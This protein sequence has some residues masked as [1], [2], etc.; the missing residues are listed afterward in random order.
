MPGKRDLTVS[1]LIYYLHNNVKHSLA[2]TVNATL[3]S[4]SICCISQLISDLLIFVLVLESL[5]H[6]TSFEVMCRG[7]FLLSLA[8]VFC[9]STSSHH[10][11]WQVLERTQWCRE[12]LLESVVKILVKFITWW[13]D[14]VSLLIV[15][16]QFWSEPMAMSFGVDYQGCR[17]SKAHEEQRP[18]GIVAGQ[19]LS[20]NSNGC[21]LSLPAEA[22]K[23]QLPCVWF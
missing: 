10:G 23:A 4:L 22:I 15:C 11:C 18:L 7:Y 12:V 16:Q 5:S 8:E 14:A 19:Q 20:C 1:Y 6:K 9:S 13:A 21:H 2:W 3:E 17:L